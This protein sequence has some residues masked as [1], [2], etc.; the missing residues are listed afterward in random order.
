MVGPSVIGAGPA[1]DTD[2]L[3]LAGLPTDAPEQGLVYSGLKLA[4]ADSLCAGSY[5]LFEQTCTHGPERPPAGLSV[6]RD[7]APVTEGGQRVTAVRRESAAVPADAEIA[8]DEGGSALTADAPALIP[9]AAPGQADFILGPDDVACS[10][11]GRS[12]KRVQLLYLH[13]SSTDSRYA[14]FLNSFRTWAAG[15]D[16]I[17][18]ASAGETGGSR[19]IRYVTTPDCRVDV[20][21]V[22]L[23]NGS[24]GSFLKTIEALR[25]LGYNRTDRK[26]LMFSDTNVYCGISTYVRDDRPSRVNRNNGGPSYARVD[27]G[28][29]SSAVAAHELTHSL[30]AILSGSPN[31]TG[32]GSCTDDHDLLCGPDRSGKPIRTACPKK[33]EIR[34]DCGHDDYFSTNPK[35]GSYLA[36]HWNVALSE[37]LLRSDGGDDIPDAPGA[38]RPAPTEQAPAPQEPKPEPAPNRLKTHSAYAAHQLKLSP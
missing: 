19:H 20:A 13:E 25:G 30:G 21:E 5:L 38:I 36:K 37:F 10:G 32:A 14:K 12:G 3:S 33:H 6:R 7:V 34:L 28:C 18:D 23:P 1:D 24:L 31:A 11:D 2:R 29:W 16:A 8:R 9:D 17:Y 22:Q 4:A 35:P 26:Y 27:S 15:V